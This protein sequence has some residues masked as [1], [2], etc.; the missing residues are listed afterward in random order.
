MHSQLFARRTPAVVLFVA[1]LAAGCADPDDGAAPP[2]RA[3]HTA[4]T[5]TPEPPQVYVAVGASE[6]VGVGAAD[7][8]RE[9]WPALLRDRE[10]PDARYVN[11]GVSGATVRG[12]LTYQVPKALAADPDVVTVWLVVNDITTLV[13]VAS[14]ER[15]LGR[16]VHRLRRGGETAVLVGNV[17]DLW[18]LPAYRA[19]LPGSGATDS[20]CLLPLVPTEREV[21]ATVRAFNT[22]VERVVRREGADLV[23]LSDRDELAALTAAD[24]FH[25]NSAGHREVAAAFARELRG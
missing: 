5:P 17:P 24:G 3:Q 14:Y 10:M 13:P 16:L 9:A 18:R 21:R 25:P 2:R 15:K 23:D 6:T 22:A 20:P 1:L 4:P 11:V 12:A 8:A 19:C 7:P